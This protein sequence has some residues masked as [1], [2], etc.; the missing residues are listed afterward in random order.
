M[1]CAIFSHSSKIWNGRR[2]ANAIAARGKVA[3]H[4]LLET[5][6]S[7]ALAASLLALL[8]FAVSRWRRPALA[9]ILWLLV[10]VKLV[11]PPLVPIY[12][13]PFDWENTEQ[14]T[15]PSVDTVR[16]RVTLDPESLED[17]A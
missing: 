17:L 3:M 6:L 13:P 8:A 7:N 15:P 14:A 5:A 11:T 10:L 12:L 1:S 9:H 16:T 2:R 4:T